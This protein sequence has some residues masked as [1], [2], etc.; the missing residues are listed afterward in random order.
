MHIYDI[1]TTTDISL[2]AGAA[3]TVLAWINGATRRCRVLTVILGGAS[4]TQ[5]DP[6]MLVELVRFSAD[7]TGTS[8]TPVAADPGNPAAIGTAKCNY[9]V[10]P[11][12]PTAAFPLRFSPIGNTLV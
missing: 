6:P 5:A 8:V 1:S 12:G 2:V 7:G 4:V 9:T 10:E 3:K 11:T